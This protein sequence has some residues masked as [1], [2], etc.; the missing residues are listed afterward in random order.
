[1]FNDN[2]IT[3]RQNPSV[4]RAQKLRDKKNRDA[5]GVFLADG[6]KLFMEAHKN[7]AEIF[8]AVLIAY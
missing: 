8:R 3:S 7:G 6:I 1:M 2:I 4:I 5:E